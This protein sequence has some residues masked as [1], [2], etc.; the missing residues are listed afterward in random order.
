M[1]TSEDPCDELIRKLGVLRGV[2]WTAQVLHRISVFSREHRD[3]PPSDALSTDMAST[4]EQMHL[5]IFPRLPTS[6]SGVRFL[7]PGG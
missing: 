7:L 4:A 5:N 2:D 3:R 1:G 6:L